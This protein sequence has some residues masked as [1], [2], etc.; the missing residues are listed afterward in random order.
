MAGKRSSGPQSPA[1]RAAGR[2][3]KGQYPS[4]PAPVVDADLA[5]LTQAELLELASPEALRAVIGIMR[6][7]GRNAQTQLAA[8]RE[9]LAYSTAKPAAK[10]GVE[11]SGSTELKFVIER[12]SVSEE[13]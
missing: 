7:P 13:E 2:P 8:A 6:S 10:L 11:H 5:S 12:V 3:A 9:L 4:A 1:Y